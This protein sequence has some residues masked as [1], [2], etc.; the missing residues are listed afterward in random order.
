LPPFWLA[1]IDACSCL[2]VLQLQGAVA[3]SA[4]AVHMPWKL[5][6]QAFPLISTKLTLTFW[7]ISDYT[8]TYFCPAQIITLNNCFH[9][10]GGFIFFSS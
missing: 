10:V 8:K 5:F 4:V 1:A 3:V 9:N 7:F 2:A 6:W